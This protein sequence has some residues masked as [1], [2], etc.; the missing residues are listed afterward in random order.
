[1]NFMQ[2][3]FSEIAI[4]F[5][6]VIYELREYRI[7]MLKKPIRKEKMFVQSYSWLLALYVYIV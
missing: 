7:D 3:I 4:F 6:L 2:Q 1:M 5:F